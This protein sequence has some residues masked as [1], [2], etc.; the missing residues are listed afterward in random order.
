MSVIRAAGLPAIETPGGNAT[1]PLATPK[2]GAAE[3][4][5]IRQ[6]QQPGGENPPHYHDREEVVVVL[7]G[8][9]EVVIE[10]EHHNLGPGDAVILPPN[11]LHRMR[12]RGDEP[13]DWLLIATAG[14]RFF[15]ADAAPAAPTWAE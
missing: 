9:V 10:G 4:S 7:G 1:T 2:T 11:A 13:A 15:H 6:C 3:V 5:V 14:I 8:R 12:N